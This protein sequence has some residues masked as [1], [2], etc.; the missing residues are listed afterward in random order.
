MIAGSLAELLDLVEQEGRGEIDYRGRRFEA[1]RDGLRTS[2]QMAD[3][4]LGS[5][6]AAWPLYSMKSEDGRVQF[7]R[8]L[9]ALIQ[10]CGMFETCERAYNQAY[11]KPS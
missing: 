10:R 3:G 9:N 6:S 4:L 5:I 8:S 7:L 11:G 2:F 1:D